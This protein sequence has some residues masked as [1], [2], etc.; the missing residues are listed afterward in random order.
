MGF[1]LLRL[2]YLYGSREFAMYMQG[3]YISPELTGWQRTTERLVEFSWETRSKSNCS[4]KKSRLISATST[5]AESWMTSRRA[6]YLLRTIA[7][8]TNSASD[9]KWKKR[10]GGERRLERKRA[11]RKW[12]EKAGKRKKGRRQRV[13]KKKQKRTLD[14]ALLDADLFYFV[15]LQIPRIHGAKFQLL[16]QKHT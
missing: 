1:H 16:R 13:K 3:E 10:I 6:Y 14:I 15:F 7:R 2:L 9:E 12:K 8:W 11:K 5:P 4:T